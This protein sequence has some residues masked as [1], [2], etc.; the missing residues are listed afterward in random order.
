MGDKIQLTL[1][2]RVLQGKKVKQLRRDGL[3]PVVVYGPGDEPINGQVDSRVMHKVYV[4]AGTHAPVH[5]TVGG[6]KK[7][8]MIKEV[9]RDPVKGSMRHVSFHA[10]N[11]KNP[12]V[13][14]IP[15]HL[16]GEG[17]SE[18]EKN[19][20]VIL[21]NLEK[22][23]VRALPMDLPEAIEISIKDL[24]E[25][26][27]KLTLAAA[28][29]PE[30]VE[31]VEH[32]SHHGDDEEQHSVT[33]FLVASVWEPSALQAANEATA[34][35]ADENTEVEAEKGGEDADTEGEAG[36]KEKAE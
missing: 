25:A 2:E 33:D 15:V 29:L 26:G 28:T 4:Q 34:G 1:D 7:I 19:G 13:A 31:F 9:D 18:A 6:K 16:I 22:I 8:A 3:V 11:A 17:E 27:E 10:V 35:D 12:V 32:E 20:Y 24:K 23:E 36:D 14:E 21:Q 5:L 30:G